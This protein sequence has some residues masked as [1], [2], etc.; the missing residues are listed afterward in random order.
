MKQTKRERLEKQGWKVG[1]AAEFLELTP[2][3]EA[4][5]ELR[6]ALSRS[7][8]ERRKQKSMTQEQLASEIGSSQSRMAKLEAGEPSVS[9]DLLVRSLFALGTSMEELSEIVASVPPSVQGRHSRT[10]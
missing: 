7:V 4:Y 8:K 2:E 9:L 1:T 10:P 3:E 6:L 5:V